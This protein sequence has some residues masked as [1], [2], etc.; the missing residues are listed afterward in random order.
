M[1]LDKC[2]IHSVKTQAKEGFIEATITLKTDLTPKES[3]KLTE[4]SLNKL[5]V[6]FEVSETDEQL[7]F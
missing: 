3:S 4:L 7:T 2:I 1:K 5:D 6:S